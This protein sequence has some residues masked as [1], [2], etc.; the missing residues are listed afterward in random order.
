MIAPND[1][2][3]QLHRLAV[4]YESEGRTTSERSDSIMNQFQQMPRVARRQ[5]LEELLLVTVNLPE[6]YTTVAATSEPIC[7]DSSA[8]GRHKS[9][10][11]A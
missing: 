3:L 4:A 1:F 7:R 6:L 2:W 5:I 9:E 10:D 11:A 8:E